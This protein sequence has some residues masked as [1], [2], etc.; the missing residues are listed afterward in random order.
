MRYKHLQLCKFQ[1]HEIIHTNLKLTCDVI[2]T[3][4]PD[5]DPETGPKL[6]AIFSV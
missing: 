4:W 6:V 1:T 2:L 3:E 5:D